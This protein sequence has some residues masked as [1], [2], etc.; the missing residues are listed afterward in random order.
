MRIAE[1]GWNFMGDMTLAEDMIREASKSGASDVKFQYW[2][3]D[4]LKAG[5]W[6]K[7]G[8]REIYKSAQ[9]NESR[10]MELNNLAQ[11]YGVKA[12]YSAFSQDCL[13]ALASLGQKTIKI[14]SHEIYNIELITLALDL[15]ET[16]ILSTGACSEAELVSVA[17]RCKEFHGEL[18]V[19]HCISSYPCA[20]E[21]MNLPRLNAL[22]ALFPKAT[23][24]L[25]DHTSS[26]IIPAIAVA[27]GV[28][29]VEKHFTTSHSLP[30]RDNQFALLPDEFSEMADNFL[31]ALQACRYRGVGALE[32]ESDIMTNYRGRWTGS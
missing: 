11:K 5:P 30:G 2:R 4:T 27:Y 25:S 23:L 13:K 6:D 26:T 9:L 20:P 12:F 32:S 21:L 22:R 15:F 3:E 19:M 31:M 8:R 14:P 29:V 24:G 16:V 28:S 7:D 10:I 1:I 18:I 17:D